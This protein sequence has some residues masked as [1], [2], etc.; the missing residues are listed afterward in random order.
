MEAHLKQQ[1]YPKTPSL[2]SS[3][4]KRED[5]FCL[6]GACPARR[7]KGKKM[8]TILP[9]LLTTDHFT[10]VNPVYSRERYFKLFSAW[11]KSGLIRRAS[12]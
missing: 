9:A 6:S 11:L 8:L 7:E 12:L 1:T 3:A 5:T 2:S 10:G 4:P